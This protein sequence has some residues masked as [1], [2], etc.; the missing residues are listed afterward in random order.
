MI[1]Y[2][3][4]DGF[5]ALI[6]A[7]FMPYIS[8]LGGLGL[9]VVSGN[10]LVTGSV[11]LARF[12]KISTLVVGLTIVAYGTSTPEMFISIGAVLGGAHEIVLGNVIGSNIANIGCILAI[13]ALVCPIPIRNKALSFDYC[14]MAA[15]TLLLFLFGLNGIIGLFEG[16]AFASIL[17]AYTIWSVAK[18]RRSPQAKKTEAATMKPLAATAMVI[19]SIAGLY[20]A[21]RWFVGGA[22]EIALLWGVS[23]RVIGIS[24]VAVGTS[25]PELT[26]SLVAAFRKE[27]DLSIGNIIGSNFFNIAGV[28]G[29][30]A[31][32]R[33]VSTGIRGLFISDM[34]W[35]FAITF[36]LLLVMLPLSKG[37]ITRLEG[38]LLLS[39]FIVYI[40]ILY[41][42]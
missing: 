42:V 24:I 37:K 12:F 13:V 20:F 28:L 29:I 15:V 2:F 7:A 1:N 23:E 32:I 19:A 17:A 16:A 33:P 31:I 34:V 8:L 4:M 6:P 25:M 21:S 35:L 30:T 11:Q 27:P 5:A 18:S 10:W 39:L 38:G 26:A 41:N 14:V 9:L 3:S 22:R 36:G 40:A